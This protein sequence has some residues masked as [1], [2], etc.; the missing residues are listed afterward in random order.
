M[1]TQKRLREVLDYD[2]LNGTFTR[3]SNGKLLNAPTVS[4][5]QKFI[6]IQI[7]GRRYKA[8]TLV[9]LWVTGEFRRVTQKDGNGLN[10]VYCNLTVSARGKHNGMYAHNTSGV[11]GV[12]YRPGKKKW[13]AQIDSGYLGDFDTLHEAAAARK[14]AEKRLGYL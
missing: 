11:R 10:N 1:I 13:R 5:G 3:K 9:W 6:R 2:H 8:H 14:N 12:S 7:D 4:Q